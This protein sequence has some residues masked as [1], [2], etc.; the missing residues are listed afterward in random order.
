VA[1]EPGH[2][3]ADDRE[4]IGGDVPA[5]EPGVPLELLGRTEEIEERL[6]TELEGVCRE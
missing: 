1:V 4:P 2:D 5:L 3:L 6:L